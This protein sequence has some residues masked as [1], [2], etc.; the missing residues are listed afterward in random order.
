[1][2]WRNLSNGFQDETTRQIL[3]V[4]EALNASAVFAMARMKVEK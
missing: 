4:P 2:G 1:M 3:S